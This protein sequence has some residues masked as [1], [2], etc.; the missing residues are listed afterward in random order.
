LFVVS[1]PSGAGKTTLC[2]RLL[3]TV[4]GIAFS[5]SYTTRSPRQGEI[6]GKDYYFVSRQRFDSMISAGAFLEWAEVHGNYY[7]TGRSEVSQRLEHGED[8]L[9][10]IDVEGAKQVR[11]L[12]PQATLIFVLPPSWSVL[13]QRLRGRRSEDAQGVGIRLANAR[14]EVQ[15]IQGYDFIIINDN[16]LHAAENLKSIVVAQRCR[17]S[18]VVA[19]LDMKTLFGP[20]SMVAPV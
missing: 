7:G 14:S 11:R 18:R 16:L 2:L 10:D 12:F 17:T 20:G 4:P 6:D 5:V 1:A 9:L 3:E 13:E 15:M 8:V 19:R